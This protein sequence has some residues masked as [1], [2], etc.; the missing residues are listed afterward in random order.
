MKASPKALLLASLLLTAFLQ[1][2]CRE[3]IAAAPPQEMQQDTL[4]PQ[5]AA[6][7]IIATLH[8]D[9]VH[10]YEYRTGEPGDYAYNYDVIGLDENDHS[11]T[12]N[13]TM[14]GKYG[15]GTLKTYSGTLI[16]VTLEW[17]GHG[18]LI[19]EDSEGTVWELVVE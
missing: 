6:P 9:T 16:A 2:A 3:S 19:A 18:E 1:M 14:K 4:A 7:E 13:I 17:V 5:A 8:T 11:V 10:Q 15:T 12:G